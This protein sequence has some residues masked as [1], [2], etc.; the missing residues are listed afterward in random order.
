MRAQ[1]IRSNDNTRDDNAFDEDE[2]DD[3]DIFVPI[4]DYFAGPSPGVLGFQG[5]NHFVER[6]V[7]NGLSASNQKTKVKKDNKRNQAKVSKKPYQSGQHRA[8]DYIQLVS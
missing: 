4:D 7:F 6:P 5:F 8:S 1:S 2:D 3:K